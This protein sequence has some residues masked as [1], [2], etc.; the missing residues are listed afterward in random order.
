MPRVRL[1]FTPQLR[2]FL[3]APAQDLEARSARE[4]LERLRA[5]QPRLAAYLMDETGSVRQ[6][7][8]V[9]VAGRLVRAPA[10]LDAP[11][12]EGAEIHLMQALSGG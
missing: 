7:V 2:R 1:H 6:H 11:L 8:A 4:A 12:A 9:F 3:D 10:E 5:V